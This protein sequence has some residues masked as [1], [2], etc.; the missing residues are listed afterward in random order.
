[1]LDPSL[2]RPAELGDP[3]YEW[4]DQ[5]DTMSQGPFCL[6]AWVGR[7]PGAL[8]EERRTSFFTPEL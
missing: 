5:G 8:W 1:M 4:K 7:G 2:P 6:E 3:A